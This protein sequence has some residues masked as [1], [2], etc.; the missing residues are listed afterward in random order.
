MPTKDGPSIFLQRVIL[1]VFLI[2]M[3]LVV[4]WQNAGSTA[5]HPV[6]E[7]SKTPLPEAVANQ[8]YSAIEDAW[9][10]LQTDDEGN[11]KIGS[12]TESAL[13]HVI[14]LINSDQ[15]ELKMQRLEFLLE[16]QF[17][18][19]ASQQF[20]DLLPRLQKYK[21]AERRWW[22]EN[23]TTIPPAYDELYRLQDK[24]MGEHLAQ[25]LFSE[26]RRHSKLMQDNFRINNDV[27]LSQD[28]KQQAL[29]ELQQ[30]FQESEPNG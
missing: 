7:F 19:A 8:D 27:T 16:K 6:K 22:V 3:A 4:W 5:D 17:G 24:I 25:K 26:H 13:V 12:K 30:R 18:T 14:D 28:E 29:M 10:E 15:A 9:S 20:I 1:L 21:E 23:G 2:F 11:L